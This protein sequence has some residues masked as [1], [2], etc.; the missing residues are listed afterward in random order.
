MK[1]ENDFPVC[2][3]A[4]HTYGTKQAPFRNTLVREYVYEYVY[5]NV[6]FEGK[7]KSSEELQQQYLPDV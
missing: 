4:K 7:I 2:C 3:E 6:E 1:Y 5:G